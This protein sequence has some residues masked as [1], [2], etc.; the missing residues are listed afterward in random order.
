MAGCALVHGVL[1]DPGQLPTGCRNEVVSDFVADQAEWVWD[2]VGSHFCVCAWS[3]FVPCAH[4][5]LRPLDA[6]SVRRYG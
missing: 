6:L 5:G 4:F 1:N 3:H 2:K